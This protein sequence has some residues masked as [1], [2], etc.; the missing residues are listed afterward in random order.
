MSEVEYGHQAT[1]VG[2]AITRLHRDY[3]GRGATITRTIRQR[4]FI[5]ALRDAPPAPPLTRREVSP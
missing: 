5:A 1:A 2:T 3:Y 4:N